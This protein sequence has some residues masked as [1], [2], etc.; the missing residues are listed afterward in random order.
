MLTP[1]RLR[2]RLA[3][4][5]GFSLVEMLAAMAIGSLVLTACMTVFIQGVKGTT[6]IENRVDTT[7]RARYA[8]DRVVR[9]LDSQVCAVLNQNSDV[10]TAP[11]FSGST[12]TSVTFYGDLKGGRDVPDRYTISYVAGPGGTPGKITIDD[13][14]YNATTKAWTKVGVT[15]T[16]VTDVVP[17]KNDAGVTQ[18]VF[19]YYPFIAASPDAPATIGD[20]SDTP[21][22]TPLTVAAAPTIVKVGVQFAAISSISHR[23]DDKTRAY[24]SGSGSL[25]TFNADPTSPSA[26]S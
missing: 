12:D 10:Q 11:I 26:C 20:V 1:A 3:A 18:P 7:M 23:N 25:A 6:K 22:T 15:N 13:Y 9:L 8:M 5:D 17:I 19:L 16:L 24:V 2:R 4:D 21:A 14:G